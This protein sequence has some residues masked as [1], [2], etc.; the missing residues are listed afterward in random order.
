MARVVWARREVTDRLENLE[1]HLGYLQVQLHW[2]LHQ[3]SLEQ[4]SQE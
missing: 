1:Q 4:M 2:R 3:K